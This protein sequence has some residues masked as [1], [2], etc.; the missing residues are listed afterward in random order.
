[1]RKRLILIAVA[2]FG[3][4]LSVGGASAQEGEGSLPHAGADINNV[5]S[6]QR[7]ARNFMNYCSGCHSLTYLRYNRMR[8]DLKIPKSELN[9]KTMF[10]SD[11]DFDPINSAMPS[12]AEGWFGK[13]PPDLSLVARSKGVDYLYSFLKGFY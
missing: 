12:D 9:A 2:L 1:M 5:A 6:L 13:Q 3:T 11:K 4:A 7:G 8:A 10:S